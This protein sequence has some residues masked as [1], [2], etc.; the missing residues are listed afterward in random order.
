[1]HKPTLLRR[2]RPGAPLAPTDTEA[3][4]PA[5]APLVALP[6]LR[7]PLEAPRF[8]AAV[9]TGARLILQSRALLFLMLAVA[10]LVAVA[11]AQ[12]PGSFPPAVG[13]AVLGITL[14]L[15]AA[16]RG[17]DGR[18]RHAAF[19][20]GMGLSPTGL[21][22]GAVG[23]DLGAMALAWGLPGLLGV[24]VMGA[25]ALWGGLGLLVYGVAAG[26]RSSAPSEALRLPRMLGV[27]LGAVG[28]AVV[29][30]LTGLGT[31]AAVL[32]WVFGLTALSGLLLRLGL[33]RRWPASAAGRGRARPTYLISALAGLLAVPIL[34]AQQP[35]DLEARSGVQQLGTLYV[36]YGGSG[37]SGALWWAAPGEA[38]RRLP[39]RGGFPAVDE[40]P[41]GL[42]S[43]R[44]VDPVHHSAPLLARALGS[45][46]GAAELWAQREAASV[47][48]VRL[49]DGQIVECP[50]R[51]WGPDQ[52][53][54]WVS[55]DGLQAEALDAS[56]QRWH[57]D[58]DGCRPVDAAA[59]RR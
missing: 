46:V 26:T 17:I 48:G 43:W 23:L 52:R 22:L 24:D 42:V 47:D 38:P 9:A 5:A 30:E 49:A 35:S 39:I 51:A 56:G 55:D 31:T 27:A 41:S 33:A 40:H 15:F 44:R 7:A 8:S 14:G 6:P 10:A 53:P 58:A 29:A 25:P 32:Q 59:V 16:L 36:P 19:W 34:G 50:G 28:A 57:L 21:E 45:K 4:A 12:L 13:R 11:A 1:M 54:H 37:A 3:Q 2:A 18:S 20:V